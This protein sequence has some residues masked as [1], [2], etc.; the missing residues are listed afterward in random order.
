MRMVNG[1]G[2]TLSI[3]V[4]VQQYM[5]VYKKYLFYFLKVCNNSAYLYTTSFEDV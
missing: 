1:Y 4:T 3:T 5:H 2:S